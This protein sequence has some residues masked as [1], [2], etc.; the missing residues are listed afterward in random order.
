LVKISSALAA[1]KRQEL[2]ADLS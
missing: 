1:S 2:A